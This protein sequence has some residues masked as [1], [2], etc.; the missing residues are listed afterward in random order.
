MPKILPP[1]QESR[2]RK[3]RPGY[4]DHP[5]RREKRGLA[6]YFTAGEFELLSK[7]IQ[8]DGL[9]KQEACRIVLLNYAKHG[10]TNG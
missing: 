10:L 5:G 1:G 4:K 6:L 9:T 7:R 3:H 2:H 8:R